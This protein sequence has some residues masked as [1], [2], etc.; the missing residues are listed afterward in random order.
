M[1]QMPP[2]KKDPPPTTTATP[3]GGESQPYGEVYSEWVSHVGHLAGGS[4][5]RKA[6]VVMRQNKNK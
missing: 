1:K 6:N 2:P 4:L 3:N 5:E